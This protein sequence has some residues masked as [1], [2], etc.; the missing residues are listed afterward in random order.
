MDGLLF[1]HS[2]H[3]ACINVPYLSEGVNLNSVIAT[4]VH[5][6]DLHFIRLFVEGDDLSPPPSPLYRWRWTDYTNWNRTRTQLFWPLNWV[7]LICLNSDPTFLQLRTVKFCWLTQPHT[8]LQKMHMQHCKILVAA[9]EWDPEK[10]TTY[11]QCNW[12]L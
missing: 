12:H 5:V 8:F 10:T 7:F 9:K 3:C 1:N 2:E 6:S 4:I 11:V